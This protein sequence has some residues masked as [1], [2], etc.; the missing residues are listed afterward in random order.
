MVKAVFS[1]VLLA[2]LNVVTDGTTALETVTFCPVATK[3]KGNL[4]N[5]MCNRLFLHCIWKSGSWSWKWPGGTGLEVS[6]SM[7]VGVAQRAGD[8]ECHM[9]IVQGSCLTHGPLLCGFPRLLFLTFL[10]VFTVHHPI[11]AKIKNT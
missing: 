2:D 4:V 3:E 10:S 6:V 11:K 7:G 5:F 8:H 9:A 1:A